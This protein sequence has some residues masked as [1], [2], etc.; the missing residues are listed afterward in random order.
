MSEY[1]DDDESEQMLLLMKE[2][3]E[4]LR[5]ICDIYAASRYRRMQLIFVGFVTAFVVGGSVLFVPYIVYVDVGKNYASIVAGVTAV[6]GLL[7]ASAM[8]LFSPSSRRTVYD[9][10]SL[11]SIVE[12]LVRTVSQYNEHSNLRMAGQFEVSLRLA[13]ADA[14]IRVYREIFSARTGLGA[15]LP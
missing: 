7:T 14:A 13:E 3:T 9:A 11:A 15:I 4:K 2:Y 5:N 1:I 12:N 10:H 8:S 6:I